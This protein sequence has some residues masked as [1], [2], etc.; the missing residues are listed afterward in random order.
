MLQSRGHVQRQREPD[1][2]IADGRRP[3]LLSAIRSHQLGIEQRRRFLLQP[4]LLSIGVHAAERHIPRRR[5]GWSALLGNLRRPGL[6]ADPGVLGGG[7]AVVW[8]DVSKPEQRI[9]LHGAVQHRQLLSRA[10]VCCQRPSWE[11]HD[12]CKGGCR[13]EA[14]RKSRCCCRGICGAPRHDTVDVAPSSCEEP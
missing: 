10:G 7:S 11:V 12:R 14:W 9:V 1:V 3:V 13:W 8:V 2:G 4:E 5:R 6:P